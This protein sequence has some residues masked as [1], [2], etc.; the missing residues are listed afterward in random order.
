MSLALFPAKI[1][2]VVITAFDFLAAWLHTTIL[3]MLGVAWMAQLPARMT[4]LQTHFTWSLTSP[5]GGFLIKIF[6]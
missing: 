5:I 3:Q 1:W 4:A 2:T 6:G